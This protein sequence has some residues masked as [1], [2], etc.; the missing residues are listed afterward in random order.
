[1]HSRAV[2]RQRP[3]RGF[4]SSHLRWRL[5]QVR[6][7]PAG[8]ERHQLAEELRGR[9]VLLTT[10]FDLFSVEVQS[11]RLWNLTL[12]WIQFKGNFLS[13]WRDELP[14]SS[15][16]YSVWWICLSDRWDLPLQEEF[17]GQAVEWYQRAG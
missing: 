13:D 4:S 3:H 15:L 14:L 12:R 2:L 10:L 17:A 9:P 6:L 16:A 5:R 7:R 8:E 11:G 1:M